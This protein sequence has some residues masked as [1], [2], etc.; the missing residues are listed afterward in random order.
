MPNTVKF[1]WTDFTTKRPPKAAAWKDC[2]IPL[3]PASVNAN[4]NWTHAP[5][6]AY[7]VPIFLGQAGQIRLIQL[8]AYDANGNV[9]Q[10]PFHFSLYGNKGVNYQSMPILIAPYGNTIAYR[11]PGASIYYQD[12]QHYPFHPN[13][14]EAYKQDG[15]RTAPDTQNATETVQL[16][17]AWGSNYEKA[18]YWPGSSAA[19]DAPTGLLVDEATFSWDT[20]QNQNQFDPISTKQTSAIAGDVWCMIYCDAQA[21]Q[22]VFFMGRMFRVEPG[23][24]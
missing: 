18:G 9:L 19:G 6:V 3:G 10:V 11:A 1:P 23:Q 21:N 13:A 22:E 15:T 14:W 20:T 24:G 17:R 16:I 2:Y 5:G 4:K 12:G 8:A 7:G